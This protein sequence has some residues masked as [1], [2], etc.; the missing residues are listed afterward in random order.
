MVACFFCKTGHVA[1]IP[2]E[3]RRM[4]NSECYT[5]ICLSKFFGGIRNTS[6]RRRI[7]VHH[8]NASSHTST[9]TMAHTT[10]SPD[11]ASNDL[12]LIPHIKKKLRGQRFSSPEDS[13]EASSKNHVLEM[14][15]SEWKKCF[16]KWFVCMQKCIKHAGDY[17]EKQ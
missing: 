6:K 13:V 5:T 15:Q 11:L 10:Y 16:D 2:F 9:Q 12:L 14:S 1:T 8:D 17:F 7:I 4:V 3:H